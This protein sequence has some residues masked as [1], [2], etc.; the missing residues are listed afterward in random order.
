M[1]KAGEMQCVGCISYSMADIAEDLGKIN[2]AQ[3]QERFCNT[4]TN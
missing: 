4:L 2:C 1:T 3:F